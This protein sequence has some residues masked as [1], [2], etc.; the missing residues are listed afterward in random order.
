MPEGPGTEASSS[1]LVCESLQESLNESL[2]SLNES[3]LEDEV[4]WGV[5]GG[6][7]DWLLFMSSG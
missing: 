5:R 3:E 4:G 6:G 1:L 7:E 2:D